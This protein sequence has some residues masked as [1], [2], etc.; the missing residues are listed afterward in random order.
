MFR[1]YRRRDMRATKSSK[2]ILRLSGLALVFVLTVA[3]VISGISFARVDEG[4]YDVAEAESTQT[5]DTKYLDI[6][7]NWNWNAPI[8]ANSTNVA[9]KTYSPSTYESYYAY[10]SGIYTGISGLTRNTTTARMSPG[11]IGNVEMR[12]WA[13]YKLPDS[14]I[15]IGAELEFSA[16]FNQCVTYNKVYTG[17]D[18]ENYPLTSLTLCG[19]PDNDNTN[20]ESPAKVTTEMCYLRVNVKCYEGGT[21]EYIQIQGLNISLKV[22]SATNLGSIVTSPVITAWNGTEEHATV[23]TS[24]SLTDLQNLYKDNRYTVDGN[25]A[26]GYVMKDGV[27]SNEV[28][29][30]YLTSLRTD[31]TFKKAYS[32]TLYDYMSGLKTASINGFDLLNFAAI[33]PDDN[34]FYVFDTRATLPD[35]LSAIK[36]RPFGYKDAADLTTS[37]RGLQ[38]TVIYDGKDASNNDL[39]FPKTYRT[40]ATNLFDKAAGNLNVTVGGLDY[41]APALPA[42]SI[43]NDWTLG[44]DNTT[45][46]IDSTTFTYRAELIKDAREDVKYYYWL[47]KKD[48]NGV[49]SIAIANEVLFT[50]NEDF[51]GDDLFIEGLENGHYKFYVMAVDALGAYYQV[52]GQPA[53][54]TEDY[55]EHVQTM[56]DAQAI[57]FSVDSGTN[58]FLSNYW[59]INT[60]V[61]GN[62]YDGSSWVKDTIAVAFNDIKAD[63]NTICNIAFSYRYDGETKEL[64]MGADEWVRFDTVN[65][66]PTSFLIKEDASLPQGFK[67]TYY[68][69]AVLESGKVFTYQVS[70]KF[71]N[72]E[73]FQPYTLSLDNYK[74]A[75][76][77][78]ADLLPLSADIYGKQG[79][80]NIFDLSTLKGG[81]PRTLYYQVDDRAAKSVKISN[82]ETLLDI[83]GGVNVSAPK[84]VVVKLWFVDDAGNS[85]GIYSQTINIDTA[86]I[87][88]KFAANGAIKKYYSNSTETPAGLLSYKLYKLPVFTAEN[89]I[90]DSE[91]KGTFS[92]Y[93]DNPNAGADRNVYVKGLKLLKPAETSKYYKLPDDNITLYDKYV[94]CGVNATGNNVVQI[95]ND[96][97]AFIATTH[98]IQKARLALYQ[99]TA[100]TYVYNG[101]SLFTAGGDKNTF[102]CMDTVVG[103]D[104]ADIVWTGTI[105]FNDIPGV[106]F[107]INTGAV[108]KKSAQI[109]KD[110]TLLIK[111]KDTN[112][113]AS[114]NYQI[115]N[116][117]GSTTATLSCY[118]TITPKYITLTTHTNLSK[119]YDGT[120]SVVITKNDYTLNGI[121]ATDD[122]KLNN[123]MLNSAKYPSANVGTNYTI[124]V[125]TVLDGNARRNYVL[126]NNFTDNTPLTST[127]YTSVSIAPKTITVAF[128]PANKIFDN[129]G[130]VTLTKGSA[131][132]PN[133]YAFTGVLAADAANVTLKYE[134]SYPDFNAG[135]YTDNI[136]LTIELEGSASGNYTLGEVTSAKLSG[137]IA[138]RAVKGV[139]LVG[140]YVIDSN[141]EY[142]YRDNAGNVYQ[143]DGNVYKKYATNG[144]SSDVT[145]EAMLAAEGCSIWVDTNFVKG[146][147]IIVNGHR[148]DLGN[149]VNFAVI[150]YS[151]ADMKEPIG[152]EGVD[153]LI[154][155]NLPI[156]NYGAFNFNSDSGEYEI[157]VGNFRA[158]S[159]FKFSPGFNAVNN[160]V[161]ITIF[162]TNFDDVKFDGKTY[163]NPTDT[164]G[165]IGYTVTF[166]GQVKRVGFTYDATIPG[167]ITVKEITYDA[168]PMRVGTYVATLRFVRA[169]GEYIAYQTIVIE[170]KDTEL[171]LVSTADTTKKYGEEYTEEVQNLAAA[172]KN[173]LLAYEK[174][175]GVN[176]AK[177]NNIISNVRYEY[178]TD[179]NFKNILSAAPYLKGSGI[180]YM[181]AVFEGNDDFNGSIS[182]TRRIII[183]PVKFNVQDIGGTEGGTIPEISI[184]DVIVD[185]SYDDLHAAEV[186][187]CFVVVYMQ[188]VP[189]WGSDVSSQSKYLTRLPSNVGMYPF[190]VV[191]KDYVDYETYADSDFGIEK[192]KVRDANLSQVAA[193]SFNAKLT[194]GKTYVESAGSNGLLNGKGTLETTVSTPVLPSIRP[195]QGELMFY[196]IDQTKTNWKANYNNGLHKNVDTIGYYTISTLYQTSLKIRYA[197]STEKTAS[198]F[199]TVK[200]TL[201]AD[202]K[203]G[204]KLFLFDSN[205]AV[206][207]ISYVKGNDGTISF[208]TDRLGWF[209]IADSYTPSTPKNVSLTIGLSAGGAAIAVLA[210][211]IILIVVRKKRII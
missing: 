2:S 144:T 49:Y 89:L 11:A 162:I 202:V 113:D 62:T 159:N 148:F 93:Y 64:S 123:T 211:A 109:L 23:P 112:L 104:W 187:D 108:V 172:N 141:N 181:R 88:M 194:I 59:G 190:K 97:T 107:D 10:L 204:T 102:R 142:L 73:D 18:G 96:D 164:T 146:G 182:E 165:V 195:D 197:D 78:Y 210:V 70:V 133:Q 66:N 177:L 43:T 41:T 199:N 166:D 99:D 82:G 94:V 145:K 34:G 21:G 105:S 35:G 98:T 83:F 154:E 180:Y 158:S 87:Y 63:T 186:I 206:T 169:G 3:L 47:Y 92:S 161:G 115:V 26:D 126:V 25:G 155:K 12:L 5:P 149:F 175:G 44:T 84:T 74:N 140:V 157:T 67:R 14:L 60:T 125:P 7:D 118:A 48:G 13:Y 45:K 151:D 110:S 124:V 39:I 111:R 22:K 170:K 184:A 75:S 103:N 72:W 81:S 171:H 80:S 53:A 71:D 6:D 192:A 56:T 19:G 185:G 51:L 77:P 37:F 152:I 200:V 116:Y 29:N 150:Y 208:E 137:N 16:N 153:Y 156:I 55:S 198:D 27:D 106:A 132:E 28:N 128:G 122:I 139:K 168:V 196:A 40:V 135:A 76:N 90:S 85:S 163:L 207:E 79:A 15:N 20:L 65:S 58:G 127:T 101:L 17:N 42:L 119:I 193:G 117:L 178:S 38:V 91:L 1:A 46:W 134:G 173:T 189:I 33:T 9:T 68:F 174:L 8:E 114:A 130:N 147:T 120:D 176:D 191:H 100:F 50:P 32:F 167:D 30:I 203:D 31:G 54:S 143:K 138:Q 160:S 95:A 188:E 69:K 136:A 61:N 205:G 209:A 4:A 57:Y 86:K 129:T 52:A 36:V 24:G 183:S 201:K 131:T 179:A 121:I